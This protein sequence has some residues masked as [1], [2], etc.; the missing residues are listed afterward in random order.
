MKVRGKVKLL[1]EFCKKVVVRLNRDQHYV[2]VYCTKNARHKQRTKFLTLTTQAESQQCCD[3][4]HSHAAAEA[5]AA[6]G[7]WARP[8]LPEPAFD[9]MHQHMLS[10]VGRGLLGTRHTSVLGESYWRAATREL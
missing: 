3:H 9:F 10:S 7:A 1:C 6:A 4:P 5:A 8:C 2:Y